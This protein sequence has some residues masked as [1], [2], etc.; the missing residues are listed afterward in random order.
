MTVTLGLLLYLLMH[1][2]I[3]MKQTGP[4]KLLVCMGPHQLYHQVAVEI[5]RQLQLLS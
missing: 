2:P 1:L 3:F 4:G 5:A